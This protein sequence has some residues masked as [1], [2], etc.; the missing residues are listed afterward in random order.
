[1]DSMCCSLQSFMEKMLAVSEDVASNPAMG[2]FATVWHKEPF[3]TS[4]IQV[5]VV[6][7]MSVFGNL[8]IFWQCMW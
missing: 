3:S 4:L 1:M 5:Q 2:Y 7:A 8:V 6:A